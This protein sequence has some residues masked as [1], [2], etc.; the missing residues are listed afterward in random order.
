MDP[1][2]G[3]YTQPDPIGLAGG[4]NR[5]SYVGNNPVN[6]IDPLGLCIDNERHWWEKLE[7]G[8]FYGT[9]YGEEAT[10]S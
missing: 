6:F 5:F 1:G 8:H 2:I 9:G 10:G 7:E 3:Q 4:L